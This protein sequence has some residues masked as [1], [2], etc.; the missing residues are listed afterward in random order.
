VVVIEAAVV[1]DGA[2]RMLNAQPRQELTL[3]PFGSTMVVGRLSERR[4]GMKRLSCWFG[5]HTWQTTVEQGYTMTA[6]SACGTMR[7]RRGGGPGSGTR[8]RSEEL[9]LEQAKWDARGG[10]M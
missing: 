1:N 5:R 2:A 4:L 7:H 6:C 8:L 9:H 10:G 3:L